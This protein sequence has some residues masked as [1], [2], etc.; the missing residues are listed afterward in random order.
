MVRASAPRNR[1]SSI[2]LL[3]IAVVFA[4]VL[5]WICAM[6]Y[7]GTAAWSIPKTSRDRFPKGDSILASYAQRL[8]AVEINSSFYREHQPKTYARW[9]ESVPEDFRFSVKLSRRFTHEARLNLDARGIAALREALVGYRALGRKLG[10]VLAQL[11]PSLSFDPCSARAFLQALR[12]GY[13]GT[14]AAEPRHAS[15]LQG[16]AL[17]LLR[18]FDVAR[19]WTDPSPIPNPNAHELSE[20][21]IAYFRLHG[22]PEIYKSAYEGAQLDDFHAR[23]A[24]VSS[25]EART[26]D[27]WCVFDNTTLG[28]ATINAL[29]L[30]RSFEAPAN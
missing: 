21:P 2:A 29:D 17:D 24:A 18:S 22:S 6:I 13:H 9:A 5:A 23:V 19:A 27:A 8:N 10:C 15:W 30:R 16:E 28:H 1:F 20:P 3:K 12:D 7:V 25:A 11:P 26:T 14:V 4:R